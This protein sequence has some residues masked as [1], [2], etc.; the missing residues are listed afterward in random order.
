MFCRA[1]CVRN[2]ATLRTADLVEYNGPWVVALGRAGLSAVPELHD[3][4]AHRQTAPGQI[5][6]G[7]RK[8][9]RLPTAQPVQRDQVD[10]L[11]L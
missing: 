6:L 2:S 7:P 4:L 10:S 3:L 9:D 11:G 5:C 8:A 1:L